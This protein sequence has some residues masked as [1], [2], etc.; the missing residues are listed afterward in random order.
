MRA[1]CTSLYGILKKFMLSNLIRNFG[2]Q[3]KC[4][5]IFKLSCAAQ[6]VRY[7]YNIGYNKDFSYSMR[8]EYDITFVFLVGNTILISGLPLHNKK[9]VI[10]N[11]SVCS[12]RNKEARRRIQNAKKSQEKEDVV[13][14]TV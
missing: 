8:F 3:G 11:Q 10:E 13:E 5:S 2:S 9:D 6:V 1:D 12:V 14:K 4:T 7:Q